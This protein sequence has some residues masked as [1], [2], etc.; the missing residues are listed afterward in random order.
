MR[1]LCKKKNNENTLLKKNQRWE[2][3]VKKQQW[4]HFVKKQTTMITLCKKN[5]NE[6]TSEFRGFTYILNY[7]D[8]SNTFASF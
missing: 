8:A 4:E 5:N 3:F 6:N 1:T 2:H 7:F